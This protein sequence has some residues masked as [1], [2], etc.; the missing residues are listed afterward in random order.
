MTTSNTSSSRI[1]V[2]PSCMVIGVPPQFLSRSCTNPFGCEKNFHLYKAR[3]ARRAANIPLTISNQ[4]PNQSLW[5]ACILPYVNT[6]PLA[7]RRTSL[8]KSKSS[9]APGLDPRWQRVTHALV[10]VGFWA[11]LLRRGSSF[12][13]LTV[14]RVRV[15]P[16]PPLRTPETPPLG[17]SCPPRM[18]LS[19]LPSTPER[20]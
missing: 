11:L 10:L 5:V 17:S 19:R 16:P 9:T 13:I 20:V 1:D 2:Q 7:A 18:L 4:Q 3:A 8:F 14:Q 6:L 12:S 15:S